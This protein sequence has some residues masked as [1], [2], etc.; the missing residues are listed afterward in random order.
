MKSDMLLG[1]ALGLF[2]AVWS[3][4]GNVRRADPHLVTTFP[5]LL[6]IVAVPAT[7]FV[8]A[9]RRRAEGW[10]PEAIVRSA[11]KIGAVAAL[12]FAVI[13]GSFTWWWLPHGAI[14]LALFGATT[15]FGLLWLLGALAAMLCGRF[16]VKTA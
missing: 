5:G 4:A 8:T 13:L 15:G 10:Q 9:R 2:V 7:I 14:S 11:R 12:V 16:I 3:V 6:P 1:V